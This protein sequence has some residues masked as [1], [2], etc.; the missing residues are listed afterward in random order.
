V[1]ILPHR[2]GIG[3]HQCF[4]LDFTSS[5]VIGSKFP[6]IV[7]CSAWKLHCKSTRLVNAY[8]SELNSLCDR[9]MHQRIYFTYSNIDSFLDADFMN[10]MNDWDRELVQFKLHSKGNATK[11]KSCQI[12]WSLEVGF[13]LA[14]RWLLARVKTYIIGLETPDP[15]NLI[16]NCLRSHLFDPRTVSYSNVMI[17]IEITHR[18]LSEL[19]KDAP[20]LRRQHLLDLRKAAYDRGDTARSSIILEILTREQKQKKWHRINYTTRST[21][22]PCPIRTFG[23]HT[24]HQR[25][26][27]STHL[28]PS[29]QA[30]PFGVL[31]T[32]LPR[33]TI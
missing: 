14:R 15:R 6:N 29:L 12:E 2:G 13:W 4:I 3:N 9:K 19:A 8:N 5:S 26:S 7:R 27:G 20:T 17:H 21:F 1:Y 18:K 10:M 22:D 31:C 30:L 16:R 33:T 11:F 24:R 23:N 25:C 28:Q 32:M